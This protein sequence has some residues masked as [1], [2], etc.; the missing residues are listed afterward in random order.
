MAA[1]VDVV[2][3]DLFTDTNWNALRSDVLSST[4]GHRHDGD[5]GRKARFS[6]L[7]VDGIGGSTAPSAGDLSYDNIEAHIG[8]TPGTGSLGV[9]GLPSW[10]GILGIP[11]GG[12]I[13]QMGASGIGVYGESFGL[14][15]TTVALSRAFA[16]NNY[17]IFLQQHAVGVEAYRS[18]LLVR[19]QA[20]DSFVVWGSSH[21]AESRD[22]GEVYFL[23]LA[24]GVPA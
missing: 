18:Y 10:A 19:E 20:V 16:N 22:Q 7:D 2:T 15:T 6:D 9:H 24:I 14:Y 1:S 11:D 21:G 13:V 23:W 12:L 17:M 8:A 5:E 4:T 3:D